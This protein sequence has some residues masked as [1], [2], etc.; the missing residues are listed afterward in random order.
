MWDEH[1]STILE[2]KSDEKIKSSVEDL[3]L[4]PSESEVM[5]FFEDI[6]YVEASP[7]DSK[8]VSLEGEKSMT[9]SN[10]LFDSNDDFI[11]SDDESLSDEDVPEDNALENIEIKDFYD[12]NLDELD[13]LVTPLFDANKDECFDSGGDVDD[14]NDFED[15]YYNS[16]G[17]ILYLESLFNDDLVYHDPSIPVM[18]V[19]SI[20]EGFTNEPPLEEN[21]DLF[22]L[23]SKNDKWKKILYD[24]SINNL[25]FEDKVF[26]PGICVKFVSPTYVSLPFEDRRNIFFTYVVRIF[27]SNFIYPVVSPFL[28]SSGSKDTIFYLDL[29]ASRARGFVHPPLE[30]QSL[31]YGNSISEIL[32]IQRLIY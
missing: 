26:D 23:E 31:A 1:L 15:S 21:D 17:Y 19:V 2:T 5:T 4:I 7:L 30:F 13:L 10:P 28:I 11:S 20:L 22:D 32:L 9:F 6:D 12:P 3:V 18:S 29:E 16:E 24:A 8:L 27:L 25:M 14:I